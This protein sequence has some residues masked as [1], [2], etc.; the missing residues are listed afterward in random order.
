[1]V[2]GAPSAQALCVWQRVSLSAANYVDLYFTTAQ[3]FLY[4]N[5]Y[6]RAP[7]L[8]DRTGARPPPPR[9]PHLTIV[10]IVFYPQWPLR[11]LAPPASAAHSP[12]GHSAET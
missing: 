6:S 3:A 8:Q 10:L 7:L 11:A 9:D 5:L 1:M 2:R 4:T 12:R